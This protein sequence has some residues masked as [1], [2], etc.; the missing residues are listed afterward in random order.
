MLRRD[1]PAENCSIARALEVLG[2]RWTLLIL[3]DALF[4]GMT[5][6]S[7]FEASLK[8][9]SNVLSGRLARLVEEGLFEV[10]T[11]G[12]YRPTAKARDVV[13]ALIALTEWGDTWAAPDGPPIV[14][15][16]PTGTGVHV[17]IRSDHGRLLT[18]GTTIAPEPGPGAKR[19]G[20][21]TRGRSS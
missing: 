13:P 1:Y 9:A 2:E 21:G 14:Y 19:R 5:R 18:P 7:E 12:S 4:R 16:T 3:R 15:R 20:A 11:D 17:E 6:Y 8:M 10:D